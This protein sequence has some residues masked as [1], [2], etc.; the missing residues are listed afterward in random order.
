MAFLAALHLRRA[1]RGPMR[2]VVSSSH[3][4][5]VEDVVRDDEQDERATDDVERPCVNSLSV[6]GGGPNNLGVP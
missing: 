6:G 2:R 4:E 5:V 1:G 3:L